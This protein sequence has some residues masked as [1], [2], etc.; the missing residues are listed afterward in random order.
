MVYRVDTGAEDRRLP[1][2]ISQQ[3]MKNA[4]C[5]T[6]R[7]KGAMEKEALMRETVKTMGYARS[8]KA[9]AEAVERGLKYGR[10]SGEI[11][12]EGTVF[13]VKQLENY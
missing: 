4:I 11:V 8:G 2:E 1:E 5:I 7:E 6:L 12:A 9:L 10:K 3:E 13:T